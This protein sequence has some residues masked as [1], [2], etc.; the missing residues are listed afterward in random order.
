VLDRVRGRVRLAEL[1]EGV[2][3]HAVGLRAE[4]IVRQG[5][6]GQPGGLGEVV[7]RVGQGAEA[8]HGERRRVK[9]KRLAKRTFRLGIVRGIGGGAGLLHIGQSERGPR[10]PVA[11][12]VAKPLLEAVQRRGR[13]NVHFGWCVSGTDEDAAARSSARPWQ[14]RPQRV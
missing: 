13:G 9:P 3:E 1:G 2:G 7:P 4:R 8:G 6:P 14:P 11:G 12:Y 10:G 5:F